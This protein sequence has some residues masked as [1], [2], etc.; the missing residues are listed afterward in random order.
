MSSEERGFRDVSI[1]KPD[2]SNK[3]DLSPKEKEK[4]LNKI[5]GFKPKNDLY[6]DGKDHNKMGKDEFLKL[7]THQL[8]HQDPMKPMEQGKMAAELAQFSQLEQLANLNSKF[9]GMNKNANIKD[10]FYGASFLGKEVVTQGRSLK[11]E[12][13]G[14]EADILFTLPKPAAKALVRI[15]DSSNNMVGEVWKENLGRGNQNVTWDGIALDGSPSGA[16][17]YS[18]NVLAWDQF[19]DPMSVETKVKGNVESVFFE[20]GETVLL[21]DGK[22]VFLRDVDSFHVPGKTEDMKLDKDKAAVSNALRGVEV[23]EAKTNPTN[24]PIAGSMNSRVKLNGTRPVDAYRANNQ[25]VG[26]GITN[27]YDVE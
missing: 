7:L 21:V 2:L 3:K 17:E 27:V 8:Q 23:K 10:K 5:T 11:F 1:A 19:S 9:D 20:N 13:E 24:L 6:V 12:G 18:V 26:T 14:T 4:L 15:Y 16:G 22:K 25:A